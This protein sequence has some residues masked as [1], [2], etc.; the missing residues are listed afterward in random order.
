LGGKR[1]RGQGQEF[2]TLT[3]V[4][5]WINSQVENCQAA[6]DLAANW[7]RQVL[8]GVR[9]HANTTVD[10]K[11]LRILAILRVIFGFETDQLTFDTP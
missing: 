2:I 8:A 1:I 7:S 4:V 11:T 5:R 3:V 6:I 9:Y 10:R